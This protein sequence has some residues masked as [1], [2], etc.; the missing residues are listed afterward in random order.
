[1]NTPA[2]LTDASVTYGNDC[3]DLD[4]WQKYANPW[5]ITLTTEHGTESFSYWTGS[6]RTD[7]PTIPDVIHCLVMD[8]QMLE[9]EPE[10]FNY[11]LG[12]KV[13]ANNEKLAK[14][15]GT[16]W[17]TLKEMNEEEIDEVF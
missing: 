2:C 13:E 7:E 16:Y 9:Q 17:L 5:T 14:L 6:A 8:A 15:F 12:K 11:V 1:M 10:H 3:T 4:D